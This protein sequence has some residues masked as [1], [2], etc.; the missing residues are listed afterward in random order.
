MHG[1]GA[2]TVQKGRRKKGGGTRLVRRKE[3]SWGKKKKMYGRKTKD[4]TGLISWEGND[5]KSYLHKTGGDEGRGKKTT[6]NKRGKRGEFPE[7]ED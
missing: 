1:G 7:K 5:G 3:T 6:I 2:K 4:I